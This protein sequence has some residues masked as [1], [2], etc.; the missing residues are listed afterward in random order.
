MGEVI[1]ISSQK[2]GV[3]KTTTTV[4]LGASLAY[5]GHRV[6]LIDM[7]PLGS[8]SASF[9][10]NRYDIVAGIIDIFI[11]EVPVSKAIHATGQEN[12]DFIPTNL[13]SDEGE[14][15][16]L[17]GIAPKIQLKKVLQPIKEDY[18]FFIIDCPPSL[19]NLTFNALTAADSIII[20]IQC[21]Y[22]ALKALGRFLKLIR[23]IKNEQNPDLRYRGFLLTMVDMRN[24]LS[25]QVESEVRQHFGAKVYRT[26][27]PRNVR[28][29]EAP[30]HGKPIL[31]YDIHSRGAVAY[32][33]LAEEMLS[34]IPKE[35]DATASN[36]NRQAE[37]QLG[38]A[39]DSKPSTARSSI[40]K[41]SMSETSITNRQGTQHE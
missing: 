33:K 11:E 39:S 7:D 38:Q 36:A 21:E 10:H 18:D 4:N 28:L 34:N 41:P 2:G 35:E 1:A 31:L 13:W 25:R 19:G 15:R 20:P 17:I 26:R 9:G 12:L 32:L 5:L 14:K 29:S 8:V 24:N 16:K 6:L 23:I 30:S 40:L 3:G 27:I 37:K 22:Y